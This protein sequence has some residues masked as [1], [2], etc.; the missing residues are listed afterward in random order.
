MAYLTH[1][2]QR[3]YF[4]GIDRRHELVP[5]IYERR[6]ARRGYWFPCPHRGAVLQQAV[7]RV[8]EKPPGHGAYDDE[9]FCQFIGTRQCRHAFWIKS[10]AKPAGC[11]PRK[12]RASNPQIMFMVC[13]HQ[14]LLIPVSIIAQRIIADSKDP[15]SIF[16]HA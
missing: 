4:T 6:R 14:G 12:E 1:Q 5:W 10:H 16:V 9:F 15:T 13:M 11:E 7:S 3:G 8:A 2:Y